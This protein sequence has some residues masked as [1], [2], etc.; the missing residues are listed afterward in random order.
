M[1]VLQPQQEHKKGEVATTTMTLVAKEIQKTEKNLRK[2]C[3][4]QH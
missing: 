2:I 4:F 3:R 1:L